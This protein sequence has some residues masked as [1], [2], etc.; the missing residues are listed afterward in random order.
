MY[1]DQGIKFITEESDTVNAY[2]ERGKAKRATG[3]QYE[4]GMQVLSNMNR[5]Q[6]VEVLHGKLGQIIWDII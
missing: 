3:S 4:Q 5:V 6:Q 2:E 1:R